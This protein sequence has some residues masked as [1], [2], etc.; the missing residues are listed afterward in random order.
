MNA[1]MKRIVH[2]TLR[3]FTALT[4]RQTVS[5]AGARNRCGHFRAGMVAAILLLTGLPAV[6][7][8]NPAAA[9]EQANKLYEQGKFIEAAAAYEQLIHSGHGSA[10][11]FYNLGNA[12]FKTGRQGRAIAAY[13]QAEKW[14]PRDPNLQ[15]N[16]QFVRRKVSGGETASTTLWHRALA[17]L[18]LNE[19][20]ILAVSSYWLWFLLLG[21]REWRPR[22]RRSLRGYTATAGLTAVLL[23]A[24]LT[25]AAYEQSRLTE[26][27]VVVPEAVVR[28]GPLEESQVKF[29]LRDG[30]EII[31][32]D[33]KE[34]LDGD[35]RQSWL[36]VQDGA[37]GTGWVKRDQVIVLNPARLESRT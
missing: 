2:R 11:V 37:R 23:T 28:H 9:F 22:L 8:E 18:T 4:R 17:H 35:K 10:A 32:L 27:V 19:W 14:N 34:L 12:W 26:A 25:A 21:L 36:Q 5:H 3:T 16:L 7:A 30:S 1:G 20:A 24:C 31:V 13:R 33:E 6:S 15:F 29:Q